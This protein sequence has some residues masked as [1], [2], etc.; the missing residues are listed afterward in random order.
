MTE[1]TAFLRD[2]TFRRTGLYSS[3]GMG[4][5]SSGAVM[6]TVARRGAPE[7]GARNAAVSIS[8]SVNMATNPDDLP[9]SRL[10][11]PL[12]VCRAAR[13]RALAPARSEG[14]V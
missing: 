8:I 13:T 7:G 11:W 10:A 6:C 5:S 4:V 12:V 3:V 1:A 9:G 2:S 14:S